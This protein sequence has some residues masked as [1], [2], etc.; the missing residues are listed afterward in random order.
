MLYNI[1]IT[2]LMEGVQ[3]TKR[4]QPCWQE[5]L[6]AVPEAGRAVAAVVGVGEVPGVPLLVPVVLPFAVAVDQAVN[7]SAVVFVPSE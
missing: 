2:N 3:R 1:T 7:V 5:C 6:I 4:N